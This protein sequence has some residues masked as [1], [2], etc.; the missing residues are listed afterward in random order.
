MKKSKYLMIKKFTMNYLQ[1]D[2]KKIIVSTLFVFTLVSVSIH[3]S[4]AATFE[5]PAGDVAALIDA[6]NAANTNMEANDIILASG[7]TYI[8]TAIDNSTDGDNGLPS[9]NPHRD[10]NRRQRGDHS[11]SF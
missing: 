4:Y 10:D 3:T 1:F 7:S 11:K 9:I 6:I 5:V 2:L 8:L